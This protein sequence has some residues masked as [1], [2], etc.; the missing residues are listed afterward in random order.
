MKAQ[1]SHDRDDE[2]IEAKVNWFRMLSLS[3]R[4][5]LLCAYTDLALEL[6]PRLSDKMDAQPTKRTFQIISAA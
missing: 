5:D 6:N 2:S 1:I 3:E 4:M